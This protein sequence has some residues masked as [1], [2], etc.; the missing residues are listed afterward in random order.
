MSCVPIHP[1]SGCRNSPRCASFTYRN[2]GDPGPAFR[3]LYVHPTAKSVPVSSSR[4]STTPTLWHTSQTISAPTPCTSSLIALRSARYPDRYATCDSVTT[5]VRSLT[6]SLTASTVAPAA[7]SV[8]TQRTVNPSSAATPS[9]TNRSV[10][11]FS[12]S[13]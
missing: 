10:G 7:S 9:T 13:V 5:A 4:T 6:A 8:C 1:H 3:N 2:D 11:K 12:A